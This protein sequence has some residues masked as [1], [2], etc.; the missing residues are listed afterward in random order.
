MT[1]WSPSKGFHCSR[2]RTGRRQS[3]SSPPGTSAAFAAEGPTAVTEANC[4]RVPG[5]PVSSAGL[6]LGQTGGDL[7]L[8][9]LNWA[10]CLVLHVE[11]PQQRLAV[12]SCPCLVPGLLSPKALLGIA[13][14]GV[15]HP[16]H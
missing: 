15:V 7:L 4:R 12:G 14:L 9:T 13:F 5:A 1:R 10:T 11:T 16:V 2:R 8:R 3:S 6:E